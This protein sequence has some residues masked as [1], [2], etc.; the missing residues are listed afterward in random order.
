MGRCRFVLA[1]FSI[2]ANSRPYGLVRRGSPHSAV[3]LTRSA[4]V[5]R[6]RRFRLTEGLQV[7]S[8]AGNRCESCRLNQE[9]QEASFPID[10]ITPSARGNATGPDHLTLACISLP[11]AENWV[12]SA[13]QIP[14]WFVVNFYLSTTNTRANWLCSGAFLLPPISP[15]SHSLATD[16]WLLTTVLAPLATRHS[17]LFRATRHQGPWPLF[18]RPTLRKVNMLQ[19]ATYSRVFRN[20]EKPRFDTRY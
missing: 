11:P 9:G 7:T 4:R 1:L 16:H 20:F 17:P 19:K 15:A 18:S 2:T 12:R 3:R 5:S 6:P 13:C 8:R 10:H 14:P